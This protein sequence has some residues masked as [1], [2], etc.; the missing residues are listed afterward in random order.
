MMLVILFLSNARDQGSESGLTC[1]GKASEGC[2]SCHSCSS[3]SSL[4]LELLVCT[5][6]PGSTD[7]GAAVE[8]CDRCSCSLLAVLLLLP[9][10]QA[11]PVGMAG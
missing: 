1:T 6:G 11:I 9:E 8:D 3:S 4:G 5:P 2:T 7:D 10:Q